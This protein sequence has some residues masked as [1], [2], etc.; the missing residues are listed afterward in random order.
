MST[1]CTLLSGNLLSDVR[2]CILQIEVVDVC[3]E[4]VDIARSRARSR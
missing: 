4:G 2:G 3:S 1:L